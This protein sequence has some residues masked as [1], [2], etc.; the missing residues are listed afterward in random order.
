MSVSPRCLWGYISSHQNALLASSFHFVAPGLWAKF[1]G[2]QPK[3]A[4]SSRRFSFHHPFSREDRDN[5]WP[6]QG[7][8][9][10]PLC[11]KSGP[12]LWCSTCSEAPHGVRSKSAPRPRP[13]GVPSSF[14]AL[15]LLRPF[16]REH[17]LKI[18]QSQHPLPQALLLR[19]QPNPALFS[20]CFPKGDW[21]L[22]TDPQGL[23]SVCSLLCC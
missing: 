10:P 22:N 16:C 8:E 19:T 6:T 17:S 14:P 15:V 1:M 4:T 23:R 13:C 21:E 12:A 20:K 9:T 7:S 2:I 18:S 11:L 3:R 5:D